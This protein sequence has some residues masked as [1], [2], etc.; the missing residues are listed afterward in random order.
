MYTK[1]ISI[2][3]IIIDTIIC[4]SYMYHYFTISYIYNRYSFIQASVLI[5]IGAA[6]RLLPSGLLLYVQ[7]M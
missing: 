6:D 1:N 5:V 2:E 7:A 3:N 4:I